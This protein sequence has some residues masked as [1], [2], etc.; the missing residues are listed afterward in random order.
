MAKKKPVKR[1]LKAEPRARTSKALP[2]KKNS[3][4][5]AAKGTDFTFAKLKAVMAAFAGQLRVIDD[6]PSKY[7][8]VTK[9]NSWR[10]GPMFFGAVIRGKAYVSYHLMPLYTCSELTETIA[11]ELKKRKQG[12]SCFNF[13]EPDAAL[14]AQLGDLTKAGLEA[15]RRKEWL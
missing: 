6:A 5:R 15:Y 10:G 4:T 9:A 13:R 2:S 7:Q 3:A 14:F 12:K 1:H 11:P 8:L